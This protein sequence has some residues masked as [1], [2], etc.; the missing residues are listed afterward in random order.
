MRARTLI[1]GFTVLLLLTGASAG[2]S[3]GSAE[4]SA[5]GTTIRVVYGDLFSEANFP[6]TDTEGRQ[7]A[8][9]DLFKGELLDAE[10]NAIGVHRCECVNAKPARLGWSCTHVLTLRASEAA[11]RGSIVISG[12]FLGFN[13]ERLAILGGT[14]AYAGARGDA[15]QSVEGDAFV[16]TL[17]LEP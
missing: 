5:Q 9:L 4:G 6:L 14:G 7:S 3:S 13:G 12:R 2:A 15:T 8:T 11:A 1:N 16:T 17:F 10:G